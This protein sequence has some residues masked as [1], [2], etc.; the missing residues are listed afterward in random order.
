MWFALRVVFT[1]TRPLALGGLTIEA[2]VWSTFDAPALGLALLAGVALV[3]WRLALGW[4]LGGSVALGTPG[5]RF[6]REQAADA[7]ACT[8]CAA[9]GRP[10]TIPQRRRR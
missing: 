9:D 5:G 4:V 7:A 1:A 10:T 3:R 2:P 6:A 8:R